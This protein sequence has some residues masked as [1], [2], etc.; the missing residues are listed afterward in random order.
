MIDIIG[1]DD[2]I[3]NEEMPPPPQKLEGKEALGR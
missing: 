1:M 3:R 2:I